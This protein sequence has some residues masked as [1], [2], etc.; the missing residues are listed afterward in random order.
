[1]GF[2]T[3]RVVSAAHQRQAETLAAE[4]ILSEWR[5][6]GAYARVNRGSIPMLSIE[7]VFPISWLTYWIRRKPS[8]YTFY[9]QED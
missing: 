6:G 7:S 8:G 3:T 5:A 9:C 1:M 2:F 4:L